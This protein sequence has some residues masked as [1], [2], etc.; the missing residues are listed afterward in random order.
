MQFICFN[1]KAS[2][3]GKILCCYTVLEQKLNKNMLNLIGKFHPSGTY[4]KIYNTL[5]NMSS[6]LNHLLFEIFSSYWRKIDNTKFE[7]EISD[8]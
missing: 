6:D 8:V 7:C 2:N 4:W 5:M 1:T 3:I